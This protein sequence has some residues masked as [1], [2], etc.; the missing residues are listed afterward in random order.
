VKVLVLAY[1]FPPLISVGGLRPYSWFKYLPENGISVIVVTRQW[2][3]TISSPADYVRPTSVTSSE[4]FDDSGNEIIRTS[5]QPNLRDRLLLKFGF[6]RYI[7]FRKFLTFIYSFFEYLFFAFDSKAGIYS[8]ALKAIEQLKPD[9]II[10]S[11]EPFILF[12]YA[13]KLSAK[14]QIPWIADYRDGWTTNQGNYSYGFARSLQI[15]FYRMLEKK[16]M[17][18]AAFI[19][20]ASPTY[21]E[22]LK[23]ISDS[24]RIEVIYNG[25]DDEHFQGLQSIIPPSNK[26]VITYA[27]TIYPHQQLEM[28]LNGLR[29]FIELQKIKA[30]ELELCFYGLEGQAQA[31]ERVMKFFPALEKFISIKSRIP[32]SELAKAMRA[33]HLLLL[34]SEKGA[35]WLNAKIFDYLGACRKI[36]LVQNDHGIMEQ[37]IDKTESGVCFDSAGE[38]RAFLQEEYANFRKGIVEEVK[39]NSAAAVYFRRNQ[40]RALS[41][42]L[43]KYKLS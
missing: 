5:F 33:S 8:E 43:K 10:A 16:Y 39:L 25:F 26:F 27:G 3:D 37:I 23:S 6:A 40:A 18:N 13:H 9:F 22:A 31:K 24:K 34:L 29:E 2:N 21:A 38:V 11:A 17:G 20:T 12:K 19:T 1:D 42:L 35:D 41:E 28:F 15:A 36:V 14:Y 4:K 30:D 7:L 32:Y